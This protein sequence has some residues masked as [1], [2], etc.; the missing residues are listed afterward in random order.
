MAPEP[1]A[2]V[3]ANSLWGQP[4]RLSA[5]S[6]STCNAEG[7]RVEHQAQTVCRDAIKRP[8]KHEAPTNHDF[9][10]PPYIGPWNQ[11]VRSLCLCGLLDPEYELRS[12]LLAD[13]KVM[14]PT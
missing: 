8:H 2:P 5:N 3:S 14:D 13:Q 4:I 1:G 11:N 6:R 9:W 7:L 10:Y 12:F